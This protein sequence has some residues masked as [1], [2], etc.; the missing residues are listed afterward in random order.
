MAA[1]IGLS[2]AG[3]CRRQS[4][5][6]G[7]SATPSRVEEALAGLRELAQGLYPQALARWGLR[8]AFDVL[9]ARYPERIEITG[10]AGGRFPPEVEA[11]LY[12]CC[13]EAVQNASKH[14]GS[15]AQVSIRLYAE[16]DQLHLEVRDNGPGFDASARGDGARLQNIRDR[17]GAIGGSVEI[18]SEPGHGTLVAATAPLRRDP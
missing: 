17:L 5:L 13:L 18:V 16:A 2:L 15:D 8:R 12:Y 6:R 4:G 3:D 10:A 7:G 9:A 1:S 11:A 14:A